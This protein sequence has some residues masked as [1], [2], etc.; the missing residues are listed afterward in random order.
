M[1]RTSFWFV[2]LLVV[3]F[4]VNQVK[5]Q[6]LMDMVDT[7]TAMGKGFLGIH[8]KF[9]NFGVT[10]YIQPQYQVI[11]SKGAK[12]FAGGDF[13]PY[14]D[15]RFMLR[16][17]RIRFDYSHFT[18]EGMPRFQFVFQ[19][20]G[21]DRGVFARDFWGRLYDTKY[22]LFTLST[23][24]M[25]R[26]FGYEVNLGSNERESP[27][28]GRMTQTLMK[29]ERDIG[30]MVSFEPRKKSSPLYYL[31]IDLGVFNGQGLN[32]V[33]GDYDG[34]KDF[35]GRIML[36]PKRIGGN[37]Y[38][39]GGLNGLYGGMASN[40][41]AR[42]A[43]KEVSGVQMFMGDSA[44]DQHGVKAPRQ[45]AGVDVQL[46]YKYQWGGATEIRAEYW[47]GT[48]TGVANSSEPPANLP[49]EPLYVRNF[50]GAIF[51]FI[52]SIVNKKHQIVLKYDWFD[53]NTKV[54]GNQLGAAGSN[55][56]AADIKYSTLGIGYNYYMSDNIRWVFYYD[57]ITNEKTQLAGFQN[58]L[59]DDVF[60][61][62]L[63]F[64]F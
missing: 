6:F 30:V 7:T 50:N 20:D 38:L 54:S 5:A 42:Y 18:K 11:Q 53:P 46:K 48:N 9:D 26:P 12:S 33:G 52:Q 44:Q 25:A 1:R 55:M 27:E 56:K 40:T 13:G 64:R 63:Q 31:K 61:C 8:K 47:Q 60:T 43:L 37:V 51:Y 29:V 41:N 19:F 3:F 39:S 22:N 28:R 62:R 49:T 23:G 32:T 17:G 35:I 14:S 57:H 10:G 2:F 34:Y 15:N 24:I 45:Y 21:T 16:R 36:R 58:D 4:S 59:K